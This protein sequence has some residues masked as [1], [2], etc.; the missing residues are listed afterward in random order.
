MAMADIS[1][2]VV[3]AALDVF[4]PNWR[5]F[6]P[7]EIADLRARMRRVLDAHDA[8]VRPSHT[9]L[10]VSPESIDAFLEENPPPPYEPECCAKRRLV[11]RE[12]PDPNTLPME[13][14]PEGWTVD[15]LVFSKNI[16]GWRC[17]L[18]GPDDDGADGDAST[19]RAAMLA[20]IEAA[21]EGK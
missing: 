11:A 4:E 9:D 17:F 19:P 5:H 1:N 8:R 15:A 14:L 6:E 12:E 20:A 2:F 18:E 21:K 13:E 10:M 7:S 16:P 3:D